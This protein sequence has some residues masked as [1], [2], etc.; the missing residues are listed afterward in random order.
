MKNRKNPISDKARNIKSWYKFRDGETMWNWDDDARHGD[1]RNADGDHYENL[2]LTHLDFSFA[3][4]IGT[5]LT[6]CDLKR[7][8]FSNSDLRDANFSNSDMRDCRFT[9]SNLK[10][11]NFENTDVSNSWFWDVYGELMS[12]NWRNA[13]I[14]GCEFSDAEFCIYIQ[15]SQDAKYMHPNLEGIKGTPR[16]RISK[17]ISNFNQ[18]I[19]F[20][21]NRHEKL[22]ELRK[23]DYAEYLRYQSRFDDVQIV[24]FDK[25]F[26]NARFL[27]NAAFSDCVF[28]NCTFEN[29]NASNAQFMNCDFENC[30]FQNTDLS[31][32]SFLNCDILNQDLSSANLKGATIRI[33]QYF[34]TEK[35]DILDSSME[36]SSRAAHHRHMKILAKSEESRQQRE[37]KESQRIQDSRK[38]H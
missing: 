7:C 4:L 11:V 38:R 16:L 23:R 22:Q 33:K 6:S 15:E 12:C 13:T 19:P 3:S 29:A 28:R 9:F 1:I 27:Q 26:S 32:A 24:L 34:E 20:D 31:N 8:K 35:F 5:S 21:I 25:D 2:D 14:D 18:S 30:N 36:E 37:Q 10:N 17:T